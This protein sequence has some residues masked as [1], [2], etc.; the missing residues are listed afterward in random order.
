MSGFNDE[1]D[2][3]LDNAS[4][5]YGNPPKHSQFKKG[6]SGNP[7]G[8]PPKK[9]FINAVVDILDEEIEI[10]LGGKKMK[11]TKQEA[12]IQKVI[13]EALN[14]KPQA[15]KQC[16]NMIKYLSEYPPI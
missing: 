9:M 1:E 3:D 8:R 13:F 7:K 2:D 16:L 6:Q 10:T 4:V 12:V 5:G 15:I 11:V 14:G